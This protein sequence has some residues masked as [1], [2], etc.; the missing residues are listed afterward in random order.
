VE[1]IF[2]HEGER[3]SGAARAFVAA[4][5]G[6]AAR[7]WRVALA[8]PAG[9]TVQQ[10]ALQAG[11]E[12]V[13]LA[14]HTSF[15]GESE[16]LR[17]ALAD[18]RVDVVYVHSEHEQLAAATAVWRAKRGVV[19]RRL[20]AGE[21]LVRG[22]SAR[23]ALRMAPTTLLV[24]SADQSKIPTDLGPLPTVV[25]DIGVELPESAPDGPPDAEAWSGERRLVC[26]CDRGNRART[27]VV[28][29]AV[30]MLAPRHRELRLVLVGPG[31]DDEEIRLHSAALGIH[32]FVRSAKTPAADR[33]HRLAAHV[34]WVTAEGDEGAFGALDLMAAGVPVLAERGGVAARYVAD[35]I[36]GV[37]VA[38]GDVPD[39]AATLATLLARDD[40]RAAMGNAGR[41]RVARAF[42]EVGM[43]DG[44]ARA[45]TATAP[46][47]ATAR[48]GR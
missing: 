26:V 1:A 16:R 28:L 33:A 42:S 19:V 22:R 29:R 41:A 34:G 2:F 25:T 9:G 31:A 21:G 43:I 23:A 4:A 36:T 13:A 14:P 11:L 27:A 24:T 20:C 32:R 38:P 5:R 15:F 10:R 18:R 46:R 35:A 39:T 6:L 8:C 37:H 47:A 40:D 12:V 44:F 30:A 48:A 7:G 3:W 17:R 45:A